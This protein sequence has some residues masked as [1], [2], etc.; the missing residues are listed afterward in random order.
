MQFENVSIVDVTAIDAPHRVTS[1]ELE[2]RLNPTMRRLN[3]APNLLENLSGI[4][5]RRM[6]DV[7]TPPSTAATLAAREVI[8]RAGIDPQKIGI[9][10]NTSVVRRDR[11]RGA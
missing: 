9:V 7:E 2:A 3:M 11:R 6:W 1:S 4:V 5:A 10:I 8:A